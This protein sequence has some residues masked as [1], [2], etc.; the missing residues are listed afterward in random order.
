MAEVRADGAGTVNVGLVGVGNC[1]SSLVQGVRYYADA[2][3]GAPGL[4][5]PVLGG[6][7]VGD[8]RFT[9][10]FDVH[11]GK[12]GRDLADAIGAEPNNA[13]RFADVPPLGVEVADGVLEDGVGES[14]AGHVDARG[15]AGVDDI[16]GRL[17][18]TGTHVLVNFL[19]VG[20]QRAA[21]AYAEAAL[22]AG[23]AYVN[24]M[25]AVIARSP[26]WAE[27]FAAAG[28]PLAG[29]DLKSQF[30]ATAVHRAL[31]DVLA[32]NGVRLRSTYQLLAGGNMDF[33][34]MQDP[35][36][37]LSKKATKAQGMGAAS[38]HVGA[39]YIPYLEDSKI[40]HIRVD[41]EA[42]GGTPFEIDVRMKVEDSPSAAGKVLDAVRYLRLAMD[43]G[44]GGVV[45][46]V[47]AELM[48][49]PP[50]PLAD[51]EIGR[52]LAALT[53]PTSLTE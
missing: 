41:A 36:R 42:F 47:S 23:C 6:Y 14:T 50:T 51:D 32:R 22:R 17:R 46:P 5:H 26:R 19:P 3:A 28:L 15:E 1:A 13:L 44:L 45:D 49:A 20:A 38:G 29:D 8:V 30:G 53:S 27:R 24:C 33:L 10:A 12:V 48:K 9:A 52:G 25:P 2:E 7:A 34:N 40:A 4:Q 18:D 11:A 16:A 43:R 39:D 35:E 31:L 21:E 37:M